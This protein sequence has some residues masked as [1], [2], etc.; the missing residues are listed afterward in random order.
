MEDLRELLELR[1]LEATSGERFGHLE[2]DVAG[3]N[4]HGSLD[5]LSFER[6][7]QRE[8]VAHRVQ[9]VHPVARAQSVESVDRWADRQCAGANNECVVLDELLLAVVG[10]ERYTVLGRLDLPARGVQPQRHPGRLEIDEA[11]VRE[12]VPVRHVARDVVRDAADREVW[13]GVG[14]NDGD[15]GGRVKLPGA[16]RRADARVAAADRHESH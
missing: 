12:V 9:Q 10:D 7:H 6:P 13:V 2:A 8:R 4:D 14:Q 3:A 5:V 16:E 11:P 15:L 1:D